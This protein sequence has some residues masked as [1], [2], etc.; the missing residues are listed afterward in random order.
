MQKYPV[1]LASSKAPCTQPRQQRSGK[2]QRWM[3]LNAAFQKAEWHE[4]CG[5]L[6]RRLLLLPVIQFRL[7]ERILYF[8]LFSMKEKTEAGKKS[9]LWF[10]DLT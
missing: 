2:R 5:I 1:A 4:F 8:E 6:P 7:P 3:C 9:S 10:C